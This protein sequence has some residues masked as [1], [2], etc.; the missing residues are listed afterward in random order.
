MQRAYHENI[1][2][3]D[4]QLALGEMHSRISPWFAFKGPEF[5]G[6]LEHKDV[7]NTTV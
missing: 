2:A 5:K 4:K 7:L 3:R 6:S 1:N